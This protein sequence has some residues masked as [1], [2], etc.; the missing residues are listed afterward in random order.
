[1]NISSELT[2]LFTNVKFLIFDFDGVFTDNIVYTTE[3]GKEFVACWRSDGLGLSKVKNL[4][5]PIWV[6]STEENPVVSKR[7]EKLDIPYMQGC[8]E[9]LSAM[10]ELLERHNCPLE[11]VVYVGNDINDEACL[12][13]VGLPIVVA[14]GYPE[15]IRLAKYVT[16]RPGGRGAVREI[17]DLLEKYH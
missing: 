7:C 11:S 8:K 2:T 6:I 5:I 17:C 1:M 16:K 14:D 3:E 12:K 15:V 10:H 4:G 13:S 9:K